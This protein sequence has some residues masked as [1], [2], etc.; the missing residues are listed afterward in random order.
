[1]NFSQT[2]DTLVHPTVNE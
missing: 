1:M 2:R